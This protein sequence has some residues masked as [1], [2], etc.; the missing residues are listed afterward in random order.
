CGIVTCSYGDD[1]RI[2]GW[3][4][5]DCIQFD[6]PIHLQGDQVK[7]VLDLV[8]PQRKGP[9]GALPLIPENN[10]LAVSNQG[11]SIFSAAGDSCVYC[12][13]VETGQVNM[14]FKGHSDYLHS[15]V[16]RN[17]ANQIGKVE[18]QFK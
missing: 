2:Q 8:N 18:S 1:G 5:K 15:I 13:D 11:G 4:W 14:I 10:A 12:W 3:R 17:S 9:W 6:M 7:P 16:A